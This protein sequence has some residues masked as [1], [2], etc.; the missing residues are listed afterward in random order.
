VRVAVSVDMEG[1]SQLRGV[2]E[3]FAALPEYWATGKPRLEADVAAAC[4]GLLAGGASEL[5]VLDN[6][7]SGNTV[8]VPQEA[9]PAG[10]RLA[11]WNVYD[12]REQGVDA[13]F[14]LGYHARGGVDGFLSHTY[15][16]TLRLRAGGELISE[17]HGRAWAAEVPLLGIVGNDTHRE[18]LGSLDGTPYLVVQESRGHA[19]MRPVFAD[20]QEGLDAIR[21]FAHECAR[22]SAS[23]ATPSPPR[24]ATFEASLPN[25]REV[26]ED[27]AA[28]GWTRTGEV[29]F[30]VEFDSWGET[31]KPLAAAMNAAL[32]P[33]LP[34]W[35]TGFAS[36]EE[37]A[38]LDPERV[39][40][41]RTIFDAWAADSQPQWWTEAADPFPAGVASQLAGP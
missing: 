25:G 7:G 41:L 26:A 5:I 6:H 10:A 22:G 28:A 30:A 29:E 24:G 17:S 3:I 38:A 19:A 13:M 14:Q 20:P 16:P 36:A 27:L 4:E 33:F 2:R 37:A 8:N 1:A 32:A 21:E 23:A 40:A 12:L 39:A 9:L 15:V 35:L 31:R 18:T 34:Y 11:T